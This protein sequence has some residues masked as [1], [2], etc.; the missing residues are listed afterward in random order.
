MP[1]RR[2]LAVDPG[3]KRVGLAA[4]DALGIALTPIGIL[5]GGAGVE[6]RIAEA[7][8]QECVDAVVIGH[9]LNMDGSEGEQAAAARCLAGKLA[10]MLPSVHVYLW[11]E[12]LSSYE[13][14]DVLAKAGLKPGRNKAQ[15]DVMSAKLIL[16]SF[17]DAVRSG[18]TPAPLEPE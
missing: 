13:A 4:A 11:D 8:R 5:E 17:M 2:V 6:S 10:E 12:R 16:R 18:R 1:Y 15:V 3:R 7:V 14:E 9:P